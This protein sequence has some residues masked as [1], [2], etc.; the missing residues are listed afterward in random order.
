[1]DSLSSGQPSDATQNFAPVRSPIAEVPHQSSEAG[2][3]KQNHLAG[4]SA[5][6]PKTRQQGIGAISAVERCFLGFFCVPSRRRS[7][8][9][10]DL[11]VAWNEFGNG[12]KH[13]FVSR[14][15]CIA[16]C[17]WAYPASSFSVAHTSTRC[18]QTGARNVPI[19]GGRC[20]YQSSAG[21]RHQA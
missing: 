3:C 9:Y 6:R 2:R 4:D 11:T 14:L 16:L 8:A 10:S 1:M 17:A 19:S 21:N 12:S 15:D 20:V 13:R 7:S 5:H 18:N